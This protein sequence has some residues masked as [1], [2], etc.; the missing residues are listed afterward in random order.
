MG[1]QAKLTAA[2]GQ[3][4]R[5]AGISA[6]AEEQASASKACAELQRVPFQNIL[7]QAQADR[8]LVRA[9]TQKMLAVLLQGGHGSTSRPPRT[10]RRQTGWPTRG[11]WDRRCRMQVPVTGATELSPA[12]GKVIHDQAKANPALASMTGADYACYKSVVASL[13]ATGMPAPMAV[14]LGIQTYELRNATHP[15]RQDTS[16][17]AE[18]Q[19]SGKIPDVIP[20]A[21]NGRLWVWQAAAHRWVSYPML[22]PQGREHVWAGNTSVPER[23]HL[24]AGTGLWGRRDGS[25]ACHARRDSIGDQLRYELIW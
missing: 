12:A 14:Q 7:E 17:F 2:Q 9:G 21:K 3:H 23:A 4:L 16:G 25:T 13:A 8:A 11:I 6:E 22:L 15:P 1:Q 10:S 24:C 20:D 18:G 5:G 19:K